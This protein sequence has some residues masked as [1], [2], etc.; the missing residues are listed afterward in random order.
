M[1]WQWF[2]LAGAGA[3]PSR[4]RAGADR[5]AVALSPTGVRGAV[6][7]RPRVPVPPTLRAVE[8]G[9]SP[10]GAQP[11]A[12]PWSPRSSILYILLENNKCLHR[13][14]PPGRTS[15]HRN[16]TR[17]PAPLAAPRA[18]RPSRSP[19]PCRVRHFADRRSD[20]DSRPEPRAG[21][22]FSLAAAR[23][24]RI[25]QRAPVG[26]NARPPPQ[27]RL[28]VRRQCRPRRG[29]QPSG[30]PR[31]MT[32]RTSCGRGARDPPGRGRAPPRRQRSCR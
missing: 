24:G 32:P 3:A 27:G 20:R 1:P 10:H 16:A 31:A 28:T 7:P 18:R 4:P 9:T 22:A 23:P 2:R 26:P 13:R 8:R 21:R 17:A 11:P 15:F 25:P 19:S 12:Q 5:G 6:E 29:G 14:H 30:T